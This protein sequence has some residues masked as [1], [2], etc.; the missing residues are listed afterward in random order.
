MASYEIE[1]PRPIAVALD[2]EARRPVPAPGGRRAPGRH[3]GGPLSK[4]LG[5][6]ARG[7]PSARWTWSVPLP[8]M[9]G[10]LLHEGSGEYELGEVETPEPGPGQVRIKVMASALNHIDLWLPR[11]MPQPPSYPHIAG[12]DVAGVIDAVGLRRCRTGR[13]ATRW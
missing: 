1:L 10:W 12:S 6:W 13:P 9:L 3:L 8:P 7:P 5:T 2:G 11:G 4:D